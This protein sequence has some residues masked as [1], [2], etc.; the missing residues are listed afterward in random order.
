[1]LII[2]FILF[3]YVHGSVDR[4]QHDVRRQLRYSDSNVN[5][6]VIPQIFGVV[7]SAG[8]IDKKMGNFVEMEAFL[9]LSSLSLYPLI[10]RIFLVLLIGYIILFIFFTNN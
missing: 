10:Q 4:G 1:M 3:F 8:N 2:L 6:G 9:E 5:F 7:S